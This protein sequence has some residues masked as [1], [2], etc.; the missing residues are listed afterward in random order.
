MLYAIEL[1][2]RVYIAGE[3]MVEHSYNQVYSY[4]IW[5]RVDVPFIPRL[6]PGPGQG[7]VITRRESYVNTYFVIYQ[8]SCCV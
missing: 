5:V 1:I 3:K 7:P 2:V 8:A 6:Q 4:N